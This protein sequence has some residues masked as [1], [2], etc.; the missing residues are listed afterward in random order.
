MGVLTFSFLVHSLTQ[1]K[2]DIEYKKM[3]ITRRLADLTAYANVVGNGSVSIGDLLSMPGSQ[4]GRAM[5]YLGFAHNSSLQYMQ[6]NEQWFMNWYMQQMGQAQ[7]PQQQMQ[8]QEWIRRSLYEQG[9]DRAMQIEQ[10]NLKI[11]EDKL[12]QEKEKLDTLAQEVEAE[13]EAARKAR[14]N[15][16]KDMAPRYVAAG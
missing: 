4:M 9:R 8:M 5:Q 1:R 16:I 7:D 3:K 13:L 14:D 2:S 12:K 15:S 10:R 11:E 6:Q